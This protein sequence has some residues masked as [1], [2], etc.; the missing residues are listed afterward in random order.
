MELQF[1]QI[2]RQSYGTQV[3]QWHA[4]PPRRSRWGR[5]LAI[6]AGTVALICLAGVAVTLQVTPWMLNHRPIQAA[7][8]SASP[9]PSPAR[10]PRDGDPLSVRSAWALE[11][12]R[13][14]LGRQRDALL[15]GDESAYFGAADAAMSKSDREGLLREFRSLRAMKVADLRDEVDAAFERGVDTWSID[16]KSTACFVA[17]ECAQGPALAKTIWRVRGGTATLVSWT[18]DQEIQPWQASE[19]VAGSGERTVVATTKAYAAKLP[20]LVQEAEKAAKVA[21]RF[22]REGKV[23]ARYVI[24]YAGKKEWQQWFGANPPDWSGGV[25][26]DV[27]IDRYELMLNADQLYRAAIDDL[28]RHEMTH[29]S[30]LPGK[31]GGR[32][33]WWLVEGIAEYALMDGLPASAH[34]GDASARELIQNGKITGIEVTGPDHDSVDEEVMGRYAVAYLGMRCM[35]ER[36]GEA[37]MI[38]FF[39]LVVHDFTPPSLASSQVYGVEWSSLSSECFGYVKQTLG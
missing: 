38:S 5:W 18:P 13:E 8:P 23:P 3:P 31:R 16:L 1:A 30:T 15:A 32:S 2:V 37:K 10:S 34:Q 4:P 17:K 12:V 9:K 20:L 36:F 14:T 24:Y 28:L 29:A 25:A 26:I 6:L 22:A 35:G 27:G 7:A 33:N 21:D 39:H 19:L 11:R